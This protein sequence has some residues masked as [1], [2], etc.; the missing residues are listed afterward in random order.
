M[1]DPLNEIRAVIRSVT[2]PI[3]SSEILTNV[4]KYFHVEATIVHPMLNSPAGAGREGVKSAYK[5]LRGQWYLQVEENLD[6][7]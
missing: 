7:N 1:Q 6:V 5:M 4:E 2:E 3:S